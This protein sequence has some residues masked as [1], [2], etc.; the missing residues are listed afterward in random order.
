MS[1]S[2]VS[3]GY[4]KNCGGQTSGYDGGH[5]SSQASGHYG[6]QTDSHTSSNSGSQTSSHA[7]G[8]SGSHTDSQ[9]S[10]QSGSQIGLQSNS[11]A[12]GQTVGGQTGAC[13]V[14]GDS[15]HH[16]QHYGAVCC[17]SCRYHL[18]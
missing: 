3:L 14:C 13:S 10:I 5:T 12:G 8:Q 15:A 4:N 2:K 1:F 18:G 16:H 6:G 9:R 11:Q 17:Y 7:Y